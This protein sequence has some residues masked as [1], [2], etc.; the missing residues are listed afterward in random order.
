MTVPMD[1]IT[2]VIPDLLSR[3]ATIG[4]KWCPGNKLGVFFGATPKEEKR[5]NIHGPTKVH[6]V[7]QEVILFNP[8]SRKLI[9]EANGVFL[10]LQNVTSEESNPCGRRAELLKLSRWYRSIIQACLENLQDAAKNEENEK[11]T[12]LNLVTVCYNIEFIWHLC[13]ILFIDVIPGG[14]VLPQFLEW[15]KF[16]FFQPERKAIALI[17]TLYGSQNQDD[18]PETHPDYWNTVT[19]L[20]LQGRLDLAKSLLSLHSKS[21]SEPIKRLEY[22]LKTMPFYRVYGGL[23]VTEFNI[24]W[25]CWQNECIKHLEDGLYSSDK[26]LEL[27]VML[28]AGDNRGFQQIQELCETWYQYMAAVL[29][30]TEPTVK[31]F[32]LSF[33]ANRCINQLGLADTLKSLDVILLALFDSDLLEAIKLIG[34][35]IE[36]GWFAAHLTD[37]LYHCGCVSLVDNQQINLTAEMREQLLLD[38]ASMLMSH[39]SLWQVG[40]SYLDHC[41]TLG[42]EYLEVILPTLP[43]TSEKRALKILQVAQSRDMPET[44]CSI[45]K[46]LGMRSFKQNRLGNALAWALRSQDSG[47]ATYLADRFLEQYSRDGKFDSTDLLEN[48]GSCM[49]LS[50]R[51]TF[52]GKYCEFH[53]L[54]RRGDFQEAANLLVSLMVSRLAPKYFWLTLLMDALPLLESNEIVLSSEDTYELLDCLERLTLGGTS[55]TKS[56]VDTLELN[57]HV[58]AS[59]VDSE[60]LLRDKVDLIRLALG[61]NLARS[62]IHEA[63]NIPDQDQKM[64]KDF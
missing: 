15:I 17:N 47:F 52:L 61:R 49:V 10:A 50:D 26:N 16:H 36:N 7:C 39:S 27:I 23:S 6:Q 11:D 14:V 53:Q 1:K 18:E 56:L 58:K 19:Q 3:N 59:D 12:Y 33:H 20:V 38:Y 60:D 2:F 21:Y 48:L 46:V 25:K 37:L 62:L 34:E 8:I 57:K 35:G 51:L 9:N 22:M 28:L 42:R 4:A 31:C 24:K 54:Y 63:C 32:D 55:R 41:P 13:E 43:L 30:Y 44:V 45:C 5:C 29:L 40:V 64:E